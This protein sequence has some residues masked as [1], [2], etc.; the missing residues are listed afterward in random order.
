MGNIIYK[1]KRKYLA[2]GSHD[3]NIYLFDVENKY[4]L[5][6]TL[7]VHKSFVTSLDWSEDSKYI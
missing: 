1:I 5:M 7:K 6:N 3:Y 2:L 4:I